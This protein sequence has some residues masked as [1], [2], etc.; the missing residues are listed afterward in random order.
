M[1]PSEVPNFKFLPRWKRQSAENLSKH[2]IESLFSYEIPAILIKDFLNQAT[3]LELSQR[4]AGRNLTGYAHTSETKVFK[5]GLS[6]MEHLLK[7]EEAKYFE[8]VSETNKSLAPLFE[9]LCENPTT[10]LIK[11]FESVGFSAKIA[12]EETNYYFA[13]GFR[14]ID[15]HVPPHFDSHALEAKDCLPSRCLSQLSWNLYLSTPPKGGDLIV[16]DLRGGEETAHLKIKDSPYSDLSSI[17]IPGR[18]TYSPKAGDLVLFNSRC[19]HEVLPSPAGTRFTQSSFI[20]LLRE[21]E[22]IFWS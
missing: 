17:E 15:G 20:G 10:L 21:H 16:Y 6:H 9:G 2:S 22:C 12:S 4:L 8:S 5:L 19:F 18:Y 14:L 1:R 7:S 3:C 13:G 11:E